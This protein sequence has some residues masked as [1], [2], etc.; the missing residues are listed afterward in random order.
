MPSSSVRD[1]DAARTNDRDGGHP[2]DRDLAIRERSGDGDNNRRASGRERSS[3]VATGDYLIDDQVLI[4]RKTIGD[5]RASL[6]DG[7]SFPQVA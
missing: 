3:P 4:E 1:V 6:V 5:L 7:P 2:L